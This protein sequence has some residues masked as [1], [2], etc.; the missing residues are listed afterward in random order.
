M[1]Q[2]TKDQLLERL[3]SRGVF[4]DPKSKKDELVLMYKQVFANDPEVFSSDD[5]DEDEAQ[6]GGLEQPKKRKSVSRSSRRSDA[7]VVDEADLSELTDDEIFEKLKGFGVD[8]GP[9]VASTRSLYVKKLAAL[10]NEGGAAKANG[11]GTTNGN[12]H[13]HLE[14]YSA[15]E[16]ALEPVVEEEPQMEATVSPKKTSAASVRQRKPQP[17]PQEQE[18]FTPTPRRSIHTFKVT[19]KSTRS[20][21]KSHDGNVSMDYSYTKTTEEDQ[22]D[23]RLTLGRKVLKMMPVIFML[24]IILA[25][26]YYGYQVS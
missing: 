15:D 6:N 14:E 10:I 17:K 21:V 4:S 2:F 26:V 16:D 3:E 12:G 7:V 13:H 18:R 24:I 11:N 1:A 9:I 22:D 23:N 8:V 25:G 20:M 5:E 19:E